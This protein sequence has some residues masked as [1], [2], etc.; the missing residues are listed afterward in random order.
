MK[1]KLLQVAYQETVIT[2]KHN[3]FQRW[4][5]EYDKSV[6]GRE[7]NAIINFDR[8]HMVMDAWK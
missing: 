6:K 3:I 5:A 4:I 7:A 1:Q 8:A 2:K